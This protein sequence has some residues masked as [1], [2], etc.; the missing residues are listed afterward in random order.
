MITPLD[1]IA[2]FY[3]G[4]TPLPAGAV[5]LACERGTVT[6]CICLMPAGRWVRWW[7]GTRS[8]ESLP[9]ATQRGV[10]EALIPQFG[11]TAASMSE[12]TGFS[13]RTVE[14]WRSGRSAMGI[15]AAHHIAGLLS[16][17]GP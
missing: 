7:P 2:K 14:A 16:N 4:R 1:N 5:P 9:P 12:A 13:A 11:G 15:A 8:M 10:V 17:A 3:A 6:A